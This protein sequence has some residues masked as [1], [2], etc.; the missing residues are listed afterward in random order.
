MLI[1]PSLLS[2]AE[3]ASTA[4]GIDVEVRP[5]ELAEVGSLASFLLSPEASFC[6]GGV[7]TMD[8]TRHRD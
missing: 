7:F 2:E 4:G 8:G 5:G 6:T 1:G 3:M